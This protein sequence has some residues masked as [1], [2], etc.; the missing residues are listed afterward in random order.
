MV[1]RCAICLEYEWLILSKPNAASDLHDFC[2]AFAFNDISYAE[3][4]CHAEIV[5]FHGFRTMLKHSVQL[6]KKHLINLIV[7]IV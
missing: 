6:I 7:S 3:I 1:P 5:G 4:D 2:P